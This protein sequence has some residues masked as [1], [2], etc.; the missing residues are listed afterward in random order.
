MGGR[1]LL[2][3]KKRMEASEPTPARIIVADDHPLFR[4]AM[5]I[6]LEKHA[7]SLE[8]VA[9]ATDGQEALELSRSFRPDLVLMDVRMPRMDGLEATRVIKGELPRTIV[10]M[11]SASE[12]PAHLAEAIKAGA[13]GYV[14]KSAPPQRITDAIR[15][16]LDGESPLNQEV[17]MQLLL[18]LM[19][20]ERK[21]SK[22]EQ[23]SSNV[24]PKSLPLNGER[25]QEEAA[26]PSSLTGREVEVLRLMARGQTNKEIAQN[27]FVSMSTV[28][29]HVHHIIDKLG[30]SDRTQ[31]VV[32]AF[33]EGLVPNQQG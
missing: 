8:V 31:A 23:L 1:L 14:L 26:L 6:L 2:L 20:E 19:D 13:A 24:T 29:K 32:R 27:L 28:K 15:R 17:A 33:E 11:M 25:P 12:E 18:S 10:L 3:R 9:E 4:S 22:E 7:D 30:V 5:C 21:E 16:A